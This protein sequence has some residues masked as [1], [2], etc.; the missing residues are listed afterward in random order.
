M[1]HRSFESDHSPLEQVNGD[2][3]L[4]PLSRNP[5]VDG[6]TLRTLAALPP[7]TNDGSK[8]PKNGCFYALFFFLLLFLLLYLPSVF[9][10]SATMLAVRSSEQVTNVHNVKS[11]GAMGLALLGKGNSKELELEAADAATRD[12]WV[13]GGKKR[14]RRTGG[15]SFQTR[16]IDGA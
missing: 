6:P 10:L 3:A 1:S 12:V 8:K 14:R 11:V 7:S 5:A 15:A 13:S 4:P 2:L 9:V 16:R